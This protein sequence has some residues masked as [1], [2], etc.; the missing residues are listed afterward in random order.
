MSIYNG[1]PITRFLRE[2][3]RCTLA[4]NA[5]ILKRH[6]GNEIVIN[7]MQE[8]ER[9][10]DDDE[11]SEG[12][13]S[14][15]IKKIGCYI[16]R[17]SECLYINERKDDGISTERIPASRKLVECY[18]NTEDIRKEQFLEFHMLAKVLQISARHI[19][20]YGTQ[21]NCIYMRDDD[22]MLEDIR[23]TYA[24][25]KMN[26]NVPDECA[27]L[28][29]RI[30]L[31]IKELPIN[32]DLMEHGVDSWYRMNPDGKITT[33]SENMYMCDTLTIPWN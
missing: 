22:G 32:S 15:F 29:I 21:W 10:L 6:L 16:I 12:E 7:D 1:I 20:S 27:D 25:V 23:D 5:L 8:D 2:S 3:Y 14:A 33:Y 26:C 24:V 13:F 18:V 19:N 30:H 11:L 17:I 9:E 28:F 31:N 4:D